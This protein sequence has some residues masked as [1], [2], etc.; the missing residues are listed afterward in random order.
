MLVKIITLAIAIFVVNLESSTVASS[1]ISVE[2]DFCQFASGQ[3]DNI[4]SVRNSNRQGRNKLVLDRNGEGHKLFIDKRNTRSDKSKYVF[5]QDEIQI[6]RES[7]VY[8]RESYTNFTIQP[9]LY[10]IEPSENGYYILLEN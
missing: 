3:E 8:L 10:T 5:G 2:V 1:Y 4:C 9:G 6:V 7:K